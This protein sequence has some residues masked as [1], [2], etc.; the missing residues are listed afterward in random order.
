MKGHRA[1]LKAMCT[2]KLHVSLRDGGQPESDAHLSEAPISW[3]ARGMR[4]PSQPMPPLPGTTCKSG[5][6][7]IRKRLHISRCKYSWH[8][9]HG[10][11]LHVVVMCHDWV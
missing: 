7:G 3:Y 1:H 11:R 10:H 9:S 2:A 8:V 5:L 4:S 6:P